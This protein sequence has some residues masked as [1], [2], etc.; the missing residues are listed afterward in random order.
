MM[1]KFSKCLL[2]IF[3]VTLIAS[4]A[5][6]TTT[7]FPN[8]VSSFGVPVLGSG[9]YTT[10]GTMYFVSSGE[11]SNSNPGTDAD[12]P[13]STLAYALDK[14]TADRGDI[15]FLM[16]GHIETFT[17]AITLEADD[18]SIVGLGQLAGSVLLTSATANIN[19][20]DVT[21]D[22]TLIE[23]IRFT[24]SSTVHTGQSAILDVDASRVTIKDCIFD[25]NSVVSIE[26]IDLSTNE[27]DAVVI[28]NQF[29][30]AAPGESCIL[31]GPDRTKVIDNDF[32]L[33][34]SGAGIGIEQHGPGHGYVIAYNS[35][36][37][38]G[39]AETPT[40]PMISWLGTP[41]DGHKVIRNWVTNTVGSSEVFG[42]DTDLDYQF[43]ENYT[44][45][46]EGT[47][48]IINP[49]E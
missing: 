44:G 17:T 9:N 26:G 23:N 49:S 45:T 7:K 32:D 12:K 16:P 8:G 11:G 42:S 14:L 37:G 33:S 38:S 28:G 34:A 36:G 1:K 46:A 27:V 21:G 35:F 41:G 4:T 31:I 10:T 18:A 29:I 20:I 15:V 19:L 48:W 3:V 5:F 22:D 6:A 24:N 30:N 43:I 25:L 39:V 47:N 2:A 40:P 13:F